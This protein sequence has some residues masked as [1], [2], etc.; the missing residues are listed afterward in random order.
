VPAA[1]VTALIHRAREHGF[2]RPLG[3][4]AMPK[5]VA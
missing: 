1:E 5:W 3:I 4:L 2:A